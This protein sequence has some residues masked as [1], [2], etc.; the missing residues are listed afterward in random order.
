MHVTKEQVGGIASC[1]RMSTVRQVDVGK[2]KIV[3][4]IYPATMHIL[5]SRSPISGDRDLSVGRDRLSDPMA[6]VRALTITEIPDPF[7]DMNYHCALNPNI[8][9]QKITI[10]I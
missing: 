10:S 2:W 1:P 7:Y 6:I 9:L 5:Y 3:P 4:Y 8:R